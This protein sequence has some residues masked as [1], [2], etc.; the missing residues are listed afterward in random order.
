MR[1]FFAFIALAAVAVIPLR[2]GAAVNTIDELAEM[3]K[4]DAKCIECHEDIYDEWKDSWH[5]KSIIDSRVLRTWRTFILSGLDKSKGTRRDLKDI[6]LPCHVPQIKDASDEL[7]VKIADLVVTAVE[8][9]D[10]AKRESAKKELSKLNINCIICHNMK[11]TPDGKPVAG[12]IYGPKGP[13]KIDA[14][15]H[16][17]EKIKSIKSEF[18]ATSEFCAGC[19][20]GCP[21]DLPSSICPTKY[22]SYK[23]EFLPRG[24]KETCQECH[25]KGEV[26]KSHKFPGISEVDYAKEGIDLKLTVRP[27]TFV[28]HLENRMVPAVVVKVEVTNKTGHGIP[29]G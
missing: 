29:Y 16:E 13:E 20:H 23:E 21:P 26:F 7:V 2:A 9:K 27:T 22:T 25:M 19:H 24:G 17:E 10:E 28:Y 11:A 5:G 14:A 1:L 15:P 4:I 3:Y 12:A 18:M 6:C 8:D